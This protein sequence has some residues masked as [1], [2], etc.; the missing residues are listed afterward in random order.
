[1]ISGW[2][3]SFFFFFYEFL[4]GVGCCL[5]L[6]LTLLFREIDSLPLLR[7]VD[8]ILLNPETELFFVDGM[9]VRELARGEFLYGSMASRRISPPISMLLL[10][11]LDL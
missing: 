3:E 10:I 2:S 11:R 5:L 8:D 9:F 1:M 7:D 6:L 4:F